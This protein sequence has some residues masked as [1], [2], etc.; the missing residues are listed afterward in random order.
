MKNEIVNLLEINSNESTRNI[1]L[2]HGC[3]IECLGV[4]V[5]DMK[6]I[7]KKLKLKNEYELCFELLDTGI[8]EAIYLALLVIDVTKITMD[9]FKKFIDVSEFYCLNEFV[10]GPAIADSEICFD[11]LD[12]VKQKNEDKFQAMYYTLLNCIILKDP[13]YEDYEV[14]LEY[15][16]SKL[17]DENFHLNRTKYQM[18]SFIA[19]IGIQKKGRDFEMIE[20]Y[21]SYKKKLK[22]DFNKTSCK[23]FDVK[24][25]IENSRNRE[26]LC[27]TRKSCRC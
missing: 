16:I 2:K 4:K 13:D 21:E 6:K 8:Y 7:I 1:Y 14:Q 26:K 12:H 19:T 27:V 15:A 3:D 22:V 18:N 25:A 10:L 23:I 9:D 5:G 11:A 20:V 24:K 17:K